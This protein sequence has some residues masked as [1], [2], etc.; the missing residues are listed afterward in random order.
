MRPIVW[1]LQNYL[2]V[3]H[4]P[5]AADEVRSTIVSF[6][7][8]KQRLRLDRAHVVALVVETEPLRDYEFSIFNGVLELN[9]K[10][11]ESIMTLMK[12]V[13]TIFLSGYAR[14]PVHEPHDLD[15]FIRLVLIKKLIKYE[16]IIEVIL[17]EG[18]IDEKNRHQD[19]VTK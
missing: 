2:H 19:N 12:L 4:Y 13:E 11:V 17:S 16:D 5:H 15:S 1:H 18:I 8:G 10:H 14:F 3:N 6:N 7:A 9:T